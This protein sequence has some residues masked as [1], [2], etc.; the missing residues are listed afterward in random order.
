[1]RKILLFLV[2]L[3]GS[4]AVASN[5]A[6]QPQKNTSYLGP[7]HNIFFHPLIVYPELG[8]DPK[9]SKLDYIDE[10][11]VTTNEFNK[12]MAELYKKGFILI[13]PKD[14]FAENKNNKGT[15]II[16]RKK[17]LLPPGKKPIILSLD[18]YNFYKTMKE[19]G[20]I[21]RFYI[22]KKNRLATITQQSNG[23]VIVRY[24]QEIPQLLESFIKKHPDFSYH[25]ARGIIDLTGYNGIFGYDTQNSHA[26]NYQSQ[27][28]EARKVV[29]KLKNMG[30]EFASHSYFH[31]SFNKKTDEPIFEESENRW[32]KEVGSIVGPTSYYVFPFGESWDKNPARMSFLESLNYHYFFGVSH[33]NDIS[34]KSN[35][36]MMKRFPMD[37]HALRGDYLGVQQYITP[38]KIIDPARPVKMKKTGT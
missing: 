34:I 11:F 17:L 12:I 33:S 30:W 26:S 2:Y 27:L 4:I 5:I 8:F 1:M 37:G 22:D 7:I 31:V 20:T 9:S 35:A 28:V 32:V 3:F 13:S 29:Q 36:V 38:S 25:N 15:I 16:S 14:V 21:H 19:H 10:W 24:D 6:N 18:D 23:K